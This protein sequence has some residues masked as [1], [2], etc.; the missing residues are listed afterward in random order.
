MHVLPEIEFQI[1]LLNM[2]SVGEPEPQTQE[3]EKLLVEQ[4]ATTKH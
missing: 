1:S 2:V 4:T 3:L